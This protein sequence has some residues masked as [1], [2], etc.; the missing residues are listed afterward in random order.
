MIKAIFFILLFIIKSSFGQTES[1]SILYE[2]SFPRFLISL[3]DSTIAN[4]NDTILTE[5]DSLDNRKY[6]NYYFKKVDIPLLYAENNY[7]NIKSYFWINH[8]EHESENK[9]GESIITF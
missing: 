8:I 6:G 1:K 9:D 7:S 3:E 2:I 4:A 5:I